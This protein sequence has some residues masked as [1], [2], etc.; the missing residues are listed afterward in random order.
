[1]VSIS[2]RLVLFLTRKPLPGIKV[3][4][5]KPV[6]IVDVSLETA[7]I[8]IKTA[9]VTA[10]ANRQS[11]MKLLST[12]KNMASVSD[13]VSAEAIKRTPDKSTGELLK[14]VS[15]T[16]VQGNK[17]VVVRGLSD[18]YNNAMIN[19]MPMPSFEPD[20]KSVSFDVFPSSLIDNLIVSKT[21]TPDMPGEFAGG[22]VQ[23]NT[24]EVPQE[25][26]VSATVG[27]VCTL[28]TNEYSH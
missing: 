6:A 11:N 26:F 10:E 22:L 13:G 12:I 8:E 9:E 14:R 20:R 16:S 25:G 19:G 18:R 17:F 15:G 28:G 7:G 4:A 1:M 27:T 24:R 5:K 3:D 23:L 21:A 2:L